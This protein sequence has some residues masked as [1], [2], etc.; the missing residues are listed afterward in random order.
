[1]SRSLICVLA[2]I[3]LSTP[4]TAYQA[5]PATPPRA[6]EGMGGPVV[7]GICFL[8][9]EAVLVNSRVG[10][11]ATQRL[12]QLATSAEAEI[13]TER[14]AI[15]ADIAAFRKDAAKMSAEARQAKDA[16][17]AA[18]LQ[19]IQAK[20]AHLA[21]EIEATRVKVTEKISAEAQQVIAQAYTERRCGL[22]LD[23]TTVLGGNLANDLTAAV[24]Q[25]L[26]K[27]IQTLDFDRERLPQQPAK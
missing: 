27:R 8:S 10:A 14:R 26:D 2:L 4:A 1:M 6:S 17:L 7:P 22:L 18:R 25:S 15:E 11:A 19:P 9:R 12:Q 24:V 20:A 21:R 13:A 3:G 5:G 16:E 23:R